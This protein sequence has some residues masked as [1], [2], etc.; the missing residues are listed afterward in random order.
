MGQPFATSAAAVA[1]ARIGKPD[2]GLG[3]LAR[4]RQTALECGEHHWEAELY[5]L[6]G[7]LLL[8]ASDTNQSK[9]MSCFHGAI[10]LARQQKAKSFELRAAMSLAR[11]LMRQ[12]NRESAIANLVDVYHWFTE[13][14]ETHDLKE[15]GDL[16]NRLTRS[17]RNRNEG[18]A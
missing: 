5:R 17:M 18:F 13:G 11:L 4:A 8:I 14:F 10:R 6:E 15:A 9:A 2:E 1:C 16:L 7:E 12:G 3:L